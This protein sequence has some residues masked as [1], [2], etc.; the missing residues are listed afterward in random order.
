MGGALQ[1]TLL[2]LFVD[3]SASGC[4][5]GDST[6][7]H[8]HYTWSK[9]HTSLLSVLEYAHMHTHTSEGLCK[10]KEG[11]GRFNFTGPVQQPDQVP[12]REPLLPQQPLHH[13]LHVRLYTYVSIRGKHTAQLLQVVHPLKGCLHT[14]VREAC[15]G[16]V[17]GGE[18]WEGEGCTAGE[19]PHN[20]NKVGVAWNCRA[21]FH[22]HL[23]SLGTD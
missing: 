21:T 6:N 20:H 5:A 8:T 7:K 14:V 9:S 2:Q 1:K 19:K 3:I 16:R 10:A 13:R 23:G 18:V 15:G 12:P 17:W 11:F 4:Q 22:H